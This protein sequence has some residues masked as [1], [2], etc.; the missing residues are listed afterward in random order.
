MI[1]IL[2][3]D[4]KHKDFIYLVEKLD[5]Y[6]KLT[7]GEE[8]D[9]YNQFNNIDDLK[10]TV[11]AFNNNQPVG[12]GA[13]KAFNS[14][15][16]EVKRMFTILESRG[17]GI[18]TLVLLALEG[19]AKELNYSSCILET[20]IRQLEA[21]QFYKKN[22]YKVISNYGQYQGIENSLCFKKELS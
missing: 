12:C 14:K 20:G 8:H 2:R 11:I 22:N 15:S 10:H 13:F 6:L 7:D 19:W 5:G 16:V 1:T 9:F 3:A 21:V 4:S 18:A 17:Q